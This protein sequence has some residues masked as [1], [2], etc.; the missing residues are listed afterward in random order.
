MV[1]VQLLQTSSLE[2]PKNLYWVLCSLSF[3]WMELH[4]FLSR[5]DH[6]YCCMQ[7]PYHLI[8]AQKDYYIL[9][10]DFVLLEAWISQRYLQNASTS[11]CVAL[12]RV[13]GAPNEKVS[14][15]KYLGVWLS[16]D[17][18]WNAHIQ[19]RLEIKQI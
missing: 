17:F 3:I 6:T 2:C 10:Q 7:L 13:C 16:E 11:F 5:R 8:K 18:K 4:S 19:Q 9:Q 12:L 14:S 15:F 1:N